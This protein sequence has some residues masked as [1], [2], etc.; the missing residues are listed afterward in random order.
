MPEFIVYVQNLKKE[1]TCILSDN[2]DEVVKLTKLP[3]MAK[4]HQF[5]MLGK[6]IAEIQVEKELKKYSKEF[7]KCCK[8]LIQ[9]Q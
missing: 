2:P 4:Y 5:P 1:Y 8:Q 7:V 6:R 3:A 9:V